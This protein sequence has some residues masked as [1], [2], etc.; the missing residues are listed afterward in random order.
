MGIKKLPEEG[1]GGKEGMRWRELWRERKRCRKEAQAALA[2]VGRRRREGLV[3]ELIK[4]RSRNDAKREWILLKAIGGRGRGPNRRSMIVGTVD[5]PSR[6]KWSEFLAKEGKDGGCSAR[7]V[8]G[9]D[10]EGTTELGPQTGVRR[11]TCG[12]LARTFKTMGSWK[13]VPRGR[14]QKEI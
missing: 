11:I 6:E 1:S 8:K 3:K 12:D 4:A 10:P 7:E 2:E 5:R 9:E 14:L 13:A